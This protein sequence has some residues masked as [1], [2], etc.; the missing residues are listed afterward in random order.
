MAEDK[1]KN[2]SGGIINKG[3]LLELYRFS[4]DLQNYTEEIDGRNI[5]LHDVCLKFGGYTCSYGK[6]MLTFASN[7]YTSEFNLSYIE[8]DL[9][10]YVNNGTGS[11]YQG[12]KNI[13]ELEPIFGGLSPGKPYQ[14]KDSGK[15]N[16]RSAQS[17]MVTF[18]YSTN[19]TYNKTTMA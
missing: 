4:K 7:P 5:S 8:E 12:R 10:K 19:E 17:T 18:I 14:N 1:A 16:L 9:I 11:F 3:A 15:N 6:S 13:I 2:S